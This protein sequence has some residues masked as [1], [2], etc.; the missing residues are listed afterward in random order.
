LK[1]TSLDL[2]EFTCS[3]CKSHENKF[4]EIIINKSNKKD[5]FLLKIYADLK[6]FKRIILI[7][8]IAIIVANSIYFKPK[9]L[10]I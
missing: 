1:L 9:D 3:S 8:F 7:C 6:I 5:L 2:N 10:K 4:E